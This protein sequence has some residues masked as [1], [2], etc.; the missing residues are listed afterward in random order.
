M[1]T[2]MKS[3]LTL[4]LTAAVW[5]SGFVAQRFAAQYLNPFYFNGA[6]FLFAALLL[7][8]LTRLRW[9]VTRR[10]LPWIVLTGTLLY[11]GSALQQAGLATTSISNASFIT[12]LYVVLVPMVLFLVWKKRLSWTSW[13]AA[14]VAGVG[15]ALLS[16]Q[17]ELRL[18]PGDLLELIGAFVWAFHVIMV[19]RLADDGVDVA[20]FAVLQFAVC[21]GLGMATGLILEPAGVAA[22]AITWQAVLYSAL[23][24][25]GMGFTLQM[26]GQK[27]APT[28]D[29]AIILSME[30]VFGALFGWLL[31]SESLS[32]QQLGGCG[33]IL[34]AML[35]AQFSPQKKVEIALQPTPEP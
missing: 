11:A 1:T 35:L 20:W 7:L 6:R 21:G 4:L 17:G 13:I 3:D 28:V 16:L 29:A 26:V 24:P 25:V 15:V 30:A 19:G 23:F 18:S 9:K 14:L 27:G 10:Q 34:A 2:R 31:M 8:P 32:L 12:G 33:L 22:F 5:G